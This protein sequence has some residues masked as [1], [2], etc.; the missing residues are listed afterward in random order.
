MIKLSEVL[1]ENNPTTPS[2]R[3]LLDA[4]EYAKESYGESLPNNI[5]L[6]DFKLKYLGKLS[7]RELSQYADFSSWLENIEDEDEMISFRGKEWFN[8]MESLNSI[9]PVIVVEGPDF[10][11]IGDGRGR[12]TYAAWKNIPLETWLLSLDK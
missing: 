1:F 12:I 9:P 6:S 5:S 7:V 2:K 8:R 10:I 3:D 4:V 11:D